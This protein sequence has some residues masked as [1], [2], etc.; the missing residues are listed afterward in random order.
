MVSLPATP[1]DDERALFRAIL[2]EPAARRPF[3]DLAA[4][5]E[6]LGDAE[7]AAHLYRNN[8][9]PAFARRHGLPP[10]RMCL[11]PELP[12]CER[13]AVFPA[14][15]VALAPPLNE[16]P[17][18]NAMFRETEIRSIAEFVDC[19]RDAVVL[20]DGRNRLVLDGEGT[21]CA[22][23]SSPNGFLLHPRR[24]DAAV[25]RVRLKGLG[26][27]LAAHN[28]SNFYH[29]LHDVL[30]AFGQLE[31]AGIRTDR[32]D[33]I[34]I[35]PDPQP[36]HLASLAMLGIRADR[37]VTLP[38]GLVRLDC[39]VLAM[40]RVGNGMGLQQSPRHPTWLCAR[41]GADHVP[42]HAPSR[43]IVIERRQ[44]GFRAADR[45]HETLRAR[46]YEIVRTEPL[47]FAEQV[48][49][50][51]EARS[52]V[53]P[54]G[55]A[56]ALLAFCRPGTEV[57][58]FYGEHVQPCFWTLS[59]QSGLRYRNYNGSS[60]SDAETVRSNKGLAERLAK[61]IDVDEAWLET[62]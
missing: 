9:P 45:V 59:A 56:L 10:V 35:G 39:E 27:V 21:G 58:E 11:P 20:F 37:I 2:D 22:Q 17:G 5:C 28:A 61:E 48:A 50:F 19:L 29:W 57:H 33:H 23:H 44:R 55:A 25:P 38:Q 8:L 12:A 42:G 36:F 26:V 49:L 13:L 3:V 31:A 40:C 18:R 41:L 34:V 16:D 15:R 24:D 1:A 54:H 7:S 47:S 51:R 53:A 62:L 32:I 14:E 6:R 46:G 43:R 4:L 60:V 30:P 52:I